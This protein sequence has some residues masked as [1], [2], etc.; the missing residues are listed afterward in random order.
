MLGN[1]PAQNLTADFVRF[2]V[3]ANYDR[4]DHGS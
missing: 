1:L 3:Q 2:I 4:V